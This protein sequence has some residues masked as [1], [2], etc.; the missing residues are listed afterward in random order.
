M[1][2]LAKE[3]GVESKAILEVLK[4][5]GEF[6]KSASSPVEISVAMMIRDDFGTDRISAEAVP[7]APSATS[8][9]EIEEG[10][11]GSP[12]SLP[13]EQ[14]EYVEDTFLPM[15]AALQ[16]RAVSARERIS[17]T[18]RRSLRRINRTSEIYESN[19]IEGLGP[20]LNTTDRLLHKFSLD[21]QVDVTVAQNAIQTCLDAEP[22]V[23]DVVGLGSAKVL[24]EIFCLDAERMLTESD[25]RQLHE[26]IMV[27]DNMGG[28]YKVYTNEI[29]GSRHI[30]PNPTDS[31]L[32]MRGLVDW[33]NASN[34]SP[35]WRAAVVH[36][37]LT[38]IHPFHD[39]N[40]RIARLLANLVLIRNLL[41]PLIVRA[42]ADRGSYLD[43][44]AASDEGGNILPIARVFRRVVNRAVKDLEDPGFAARLFEAEIERRYEPLYDRWQSALNSFLDELAARL[45]LSKLGLER[46]GNVENAEFTRFRQGWRG[47]VWLAKVRVPG[48]T[49]DLLLHVAQPSTVNR[50]SLERDEEF[51]T[52]FVSV[53]NQRSLDAKQYLPVG[54]DFFSYEFTPIVDTGTVL[55]RAHRDA[56]KL[57]TVDAAT[58]VANHLERVARQLIVR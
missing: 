44:L 3:F 35:L 41:P 6:V 56:R 47:N 24:A 15:I 29:F 10:L 27:G 32:Q 46:V 14:Q 55:V 51:P 16:I 23:R 57:P 28:S 8:F 11:A 33:L 34:L 4:A 58:A 13:R 43:A 39:G 7:F 31:R 53:R 42:A 1:H 17:T 12:Y 19:R 37:W 9:Q 36:A 5:R 49:Q 45:R 48:K 21:S 30:P 2:E 25:I 20:N 18:G 38:H 52:V 50:R 40:G 54:R 22:K 26:L